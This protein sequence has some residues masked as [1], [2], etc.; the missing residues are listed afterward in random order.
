MMKWALCHSSHSA[1]IHVMPL[2]DLREHVDTESCWCCPRR[3]FDED[4][5]IVH[6]AM[7]NRESYEEG[8]LQ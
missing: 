6:K 2:E 1:D 3:D 7:D 8:R 4:D 5:V